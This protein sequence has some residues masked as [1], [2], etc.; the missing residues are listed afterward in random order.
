MNR[1]RRRKPKNVRITRA[2]T[3]TPSNCGDFGR[4]PEEVFQLIIEFL[5]LQDV[6]K[7]K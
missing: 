5:P 4:I 7:V 3:R 6:G 2:P 1:N